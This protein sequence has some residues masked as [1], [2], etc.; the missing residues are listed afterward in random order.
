M[1]NEPEEIVMPKMPFLLMKHD[2][3]RDRVQPLMSS[4]VLTEQELALVSGGI[5]P[6]ETNVFTYNPKTGTNTD[7]GCD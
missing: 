5:E 1:R 3:E 2:S 6:C 4:R 7:R